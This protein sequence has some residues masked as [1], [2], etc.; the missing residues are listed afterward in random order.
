[1]RRNAVERQAFH[2]L[3]W[4]MAPLRSVQ[5]RQDFRAMRQMHPPATLT[6][7]AVKSS[8]AD[9]FCALKEQKE[10]ES[11]PTTYNFVVVWV[12]IL[13][14]F[15]AYSAPVCLYIHTQSVALGSIPV[16]ASPCLCSNIN[17]QKYLR[18]RPAF[19]KIITQQFDLCNIVSN[20]LMI[21]ICNQCQKRN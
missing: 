4:R 2:V 18:L 15:C 14:S 10:G 7:Q 9:A 19:A 3:F 1:M 16:G 8:F 20:N 21:N 13:S 6:V 11:V 5:K 12:W 17:S